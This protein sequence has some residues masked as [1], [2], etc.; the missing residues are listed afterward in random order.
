MLESLGPDSRG[1]SEPPAKKV[2]HSI[3]R[4]LVDVYGNGDSE[5]RGQ[6]AIYGFPRLKPQTGAR[7]SLSNA[8][9][10]SGDSSSKSL[11]R[12]EDVMFEIFG[13]SHVDGG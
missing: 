10:Q 11:P 4:P 8:A 5:S 13:D 3:L 12:E 1:E 6:R 2:A 9:L 7:K